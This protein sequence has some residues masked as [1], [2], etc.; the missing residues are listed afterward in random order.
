MSHANN[1]SG[2]A[3][4][5]LAKAP[6][7]GLTKTRLIPY[8]GA[9][10]AA[11]LQDWLL[12][13]TVATA[14]NSNLGPVTLWCAPDTAHPAF[15]DLAVGGRI[16]LRQQREGNLGERMHQA[17]AESPMTGGTLVIG[18][19]CPA[20]G[21]AHLQAAAAALAAY[22]AVV[23]PAEDG[24]YVLIGMRQPSWRVFTGINWGSAKVMTQT[25]ERL[26]ETGRQWSELPSLWDVDREEDFER[27]GALLPDDF[28]P[29]R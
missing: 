17:L 21:P 13:R 24:G 6:I 4:A 29:G 2:I 11:T 3:I 20:L 5:I 27:L 8:L 28:L 19:D 16:A 26:L 15:V 18:T 1:N 9:D 22:Q 14:L 12:R 25:R 10:G 7:P 23:I